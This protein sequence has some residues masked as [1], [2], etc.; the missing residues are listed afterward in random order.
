MTVM[1]IDMNAFFASVEQRCNPSLRGKPIAVIGSA[2]RTVVTTASYE[3]RAHGVKTGMNKYEAKRACPGLVFVVGDNRKYIDTSVRILNIFKQFS[4]IV[5][6]YS[7]DEAFVDI[8]GTAALFGPPLTLALSV[9]ERIRQEVGLTC[10]IGIAPNKLLA[11]LASDMKKP[12]GLV[13]IEEGEVSSVLEDLPV[14]ELWGVGPRLTAHLST[15][16]IKTCGQLGRYP[17]SVLR[18]RF[19]IIGERLKLMGQGID[20]NPVVPIGEEEEAKSVGHSTTLPK[21][22]SDKEALKRYLLKLS[23]MV[24]FRARGHKLKGR[25]IT[26]TLRYNDFFTF[27]R[28]RSLSFPTNDTR[29]IYAAASGILDSIRLRTSIRL[30]GVSISDI[31]AGCT[32]MELFDEGRKRESLLQAI[33]SINRDLGEFTITWGTLLEEEC[34]RHGPG[35]ISPAWRPEGVK[36]VN[37]R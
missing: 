35:V 12:D 9:K 36:R 1:H 3:A 8:T 37:V 11:K 13:V 34:G 26:L 19:G 21:D 20:P 4:P 29:A 16:A 32:Q 17:V 15:L 24:G 30:I 5:E 7:I 28:Q 6:A 33:D 23:E 14:C 31:V 25:K 2:G 10:S 18:E 22:I 27:G